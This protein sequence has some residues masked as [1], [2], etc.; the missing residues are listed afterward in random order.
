[1][2]KESPRH[3]A[4]TRPIVFVLLLTKN[5]G[6]QSATFIEHTRF[7]PLFIMPSAAA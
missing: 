5:T 7:P 3:P 4:C 1:M 2:P 6:K